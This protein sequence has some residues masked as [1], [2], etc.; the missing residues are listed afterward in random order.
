MSEDKNQSIDSRLAQAC[1]YLDEAT[2]GVN[3]PLQLS[4]TYARDQNYDFVGDYSYGR[5]GNPTW[6]LLERV[7]ADLDGGAAALCFASGMA[8]V[9]T[10]FETLNSGEHVAAPRIMYHGAQDWLRRIS[11]RRGIGL[12]F[13]D[14]ADPEDLARAIEPGRTAIL[15]VETPVNPTWDVIDIAAAAE[16]AHA[17]GAL[18]AVDATV[19]TPVTTRPLELG[20]DIVFHSATKY[21]N[22]HSDVV[23]G[24]LVTAKDDARWDEINEVRKL[25]GG[26]LGP[27]E[28]WLLLR[29]M[30]T[31]AVRFDQASR[32][33][34]AIARYFEDHPAIEQ[35]L[36]PGLESHP[37]H[38]IA[39][40]QMTRG[41]GGMLSLLVKG[42][43]ATAKSIAGRTRLFV[44]ATSLGGVESLIEHRA[45]V[46]GPMSAVPPNL[47][48]LSV[49]IERAD[50]LIDDLERSLNPD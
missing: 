2:G 48:R 26:V 16:V 28:A 33:A 7:C 30:R 43:A 32:N 39:R 19:S 42:D 25:T 29:G 27:V 14:A 8:A 20:A 18:L 31:L 50:E 46:E 35:V 22:G 3:P 1:H 40:R 15:W 12:T 23:A 17:A 36:Y 41:F 24:I 5:N 10:L 45:S 47:L 6:A 13:Y 49:G 44:R 11:E 37:G 4:S 9:C 21:M 34:L 38:A